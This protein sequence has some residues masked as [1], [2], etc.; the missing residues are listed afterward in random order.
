MAK[1]T[2]KIFTTPT[3]VY[4]VMAKQFFKEK[5]VEYNELDVSKDRSA[6]EE[7]IEKSGQMGVPVIE[8]DGKI[9]LG[10]DKPALKQALEI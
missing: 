3:C 7:M 6:A 2:V 1:H 10:F 9:I 5:K 8:V 4:C